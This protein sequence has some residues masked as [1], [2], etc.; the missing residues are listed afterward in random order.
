MS[1]LMLIWTIPTVGEVLGLND[2]V[3]LGRIAGCSLFTISVGIALGWIVGSLLRSSVGVLLGLSVGEDVFA[4][5]G[6]AEGSVPFGVILGN[7][8]GVIIGLRLGTKG[9]G[10]IDGTSVFGTTVSGA[11]E[12]SDGGCAGACMGCVCTRTSFMI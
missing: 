7:K 2:W 11:G 3:T 12:R 6:R 8:V 1:R 9:T 4:S 10:L 5:L